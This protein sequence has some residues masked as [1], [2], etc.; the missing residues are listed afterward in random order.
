M[1]E[2]AVS[3]AAA[4][5]EQVSL[6]LRSRSAALF[7]AQG[8]GH[9][10]PRPQRLEVRPST[11]RGLLLKRVSIRGERATRFS[12]LPIAFPIVGPVSTR[13]STRGFRPFLR[14]KGGKPRTYA[15]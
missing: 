2:E 7:R 8:E 13:G 3:R 5:S 15:A 1:T 6:L 12:G 14:N 9:G 4:R 10:G 11:R